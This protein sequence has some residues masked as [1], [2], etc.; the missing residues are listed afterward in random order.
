MT[1]PQW[2]QPQPA[3]QWHQPGQWQQAGQWQQP[4][5]P[6][7]AHAGAYQPIAPVSPADPARRPSWFTWARN[8]CSIVAV[9]VAAAYIAIAETSHFVIVGI[10]PIALAIRGA[11]RREPLSPVAV[12]AAIATVAITLHALAG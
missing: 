7:P 6:Y 2:P 4:A 9:I 10:I 11:A 12:V 8:Q 3:E 5:N 1:N